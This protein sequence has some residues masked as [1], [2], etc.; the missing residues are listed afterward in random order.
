MLKITKYEPQTH[1]IRSLVKY[2]WV[3]DSSASNLM[4]NNTLLPVCNIDL[5]L[6][7][8]NPITYI[9]SEG[10]DETIV[11]GLHFNGISS[12]YRIL[13]QEGKLFVIGISFYPMGLYA[14]LQKPL[15]EYKDST[16]DLNLVLRE[17]TQKVANLLEGAQS[18]TEKLFV[19]EQELTGFVNTECIPSSKTLNIYK[20]FYKNIM[21]SRINEFCTCYGISQRALERLFNKYIGICPK[22]FQKLARFQKIVNQIMKSKYQDLTFLAHQYNYYDQNHFI[23]EFKSLAGATPTHFINE[24]RSIK[25]II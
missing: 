15:Y 18:T 19:L 7:F 24:K 4:V 25:H 1:L 16:I 23:K 14:L 17:F 20:A 6:N 10:N 2:F 8:S 3:I 5:I 12:K 11:R 21:N 22:E 9:N 13:V